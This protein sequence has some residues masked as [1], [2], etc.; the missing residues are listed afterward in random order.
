[1]GASEA[2]ILIVQSN[3]AVTYQELQR[4]EEASSMQRD[5]YSG[6]LK[7]HGE[8]HERTLGAAL[9]YATTLV[10]LRRYAEAKAVLRRTIPVARRVLG[11]NND[12][13][14]TF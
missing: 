11:E 8:E 12:D 10:Q 14:H 1:M 3:L 5:V 6:R 2:Y 4:L 9:N 13:V 7:L